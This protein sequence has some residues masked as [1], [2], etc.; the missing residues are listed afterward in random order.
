MTRA[1][2]YDEEIARYE[3]ELKRLKA[4]R[5]K[6]QRREENVELKQLKIQND[7]LTQECRTLQAQCDAMEEWLR[8]K[9][10]VK[11][12]G[13]TVIFW[14]IFVRSYPEYDHPTIW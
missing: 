12:T 7:L 11:A 9:R 3:S 2:D 14:N 4:D 8:R 6:L 10:T 5:R 1:S 13:K